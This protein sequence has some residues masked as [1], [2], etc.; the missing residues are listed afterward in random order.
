M[1]QLIFTKEGFEIPEETVTVIRKKEPY[2]IPAEKVI[3]GDTLCVRGLGTGFS[4][5]GSYELGII[6]G[7]Y[8]GDGTNASGRPRLYFYGDKMSLVPEFLNAI[9]LLIGKEIPVCTATPGRKSVE[10]KLLSAHLPLD[11]TAIP[12]QILK[13]SK[14]CQRG[15]ISAIFSADGSIQGNINKGLSVRLH[16]I[17]LEM[18]K[19]IQRMLLNFSIFSKIYQNRMKEGFRSLPNGRGNLKEYWC[20]TSHELCISKSSLISF[21]SHIGFLQEEKNTKLQNLLTSYKKGPYQDRFTAKVIGIQ[22][23][24]MR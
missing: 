16:S 5:T 24:K 7:W 22:L 4:A 10:S 8:A 19:N 23:E 18:L 12:Q 17:D 9:K 6:A 2:I 3:I 20:K 11:K 13:G 14:D 21:G 15:F 1:K